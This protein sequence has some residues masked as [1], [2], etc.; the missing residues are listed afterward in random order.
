MKLV[1]IR[2]QTAF[3]HKSLQLPVPLNGLSR[4]T[5][6]VP[7]INIAAFYDKDYKVFTLKL[8]DW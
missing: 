1:N 6:W 3:V 8:I 7:T 2:K 4:K 5:F